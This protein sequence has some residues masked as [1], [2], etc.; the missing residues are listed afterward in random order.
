M[1]KVILL[2]FRLIVSPTTF[3]NSSFEWGCPSGNAYPEERKFLRRDLSPTVSVPVSV[4]SHEKWV[5]CQAVIFCRNA[6][7]CP[8]TSGFS[9]GSPK[10]Q[11]HGVLLAH[12]STQCKPLII[13]LFVL[14]LHNTSVLSGRL[15]L[16]HLQ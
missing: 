10:R 2:S 6:P 1:L 3:N 4:L 14:L 16:A 13:S 8:E 11:S 5:V 15:K 12:Y 7:E 9:L